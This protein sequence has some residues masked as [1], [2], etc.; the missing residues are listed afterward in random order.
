[1]DKSST[2]LCPRG[3][4]DFDTSSKLNIAI[5]SLSGQSPKARTFASII[6]NSVET[7]VNLS[8]LPISIVQGDV[9]YVKISENLY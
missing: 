2:A 6:T 5:G 9:T 1:M 8:Q 4:L 3:F 7:S